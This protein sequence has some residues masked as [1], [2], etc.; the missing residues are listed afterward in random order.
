M[1]GFPKTLSSKEDYLYVKE[2]FDREQWVPEFQ[3]LLDA[4]MVWMP[5]GT[6]ADESAGVTDATRKVVVDEQA[7]PKTYTQYELQE[8]P[9]AKIF[10]LGFTVAEV[11][12]AL[13]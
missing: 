5:T 11:Q 2:H 3:A 13:R 12:A 4:R 10:R 6:V 9:D 8:N 7:D 1:R